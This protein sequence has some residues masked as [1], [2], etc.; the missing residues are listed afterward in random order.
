MFSSFLFERVPGSLLSSK[1][2]LHQD[3]LPE[4]DRRIL[5]S[6]PAAIAVDDSPLL[7]PIRTPHQGTQQHWRKIDE[8]PSGL[9]LSATLGCA[10]IKSVFH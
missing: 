2:S 7:I 3:R 10:D 5:L 9:R 4:R 1:H 8:D 6:I